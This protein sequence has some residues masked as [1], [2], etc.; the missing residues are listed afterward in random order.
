RIGAD[1]DAQAIRDPE[2]KALAI[3]G[4]RR[5]EADVREYYETVCAAF[6]VQPPADIE[7]IAAALLAAYDGLAV[8]ALIDPDFEPVPALRAL[9]RM[10]VAI[11]APGAGPVDRD[12]DFGPF[13]P[14]EEEGE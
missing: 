10:Q 8:R 3:A 12:W 2:I 11:L 9:E 13:E 14:R 5:G 4:K 1:L 7:G 6:G